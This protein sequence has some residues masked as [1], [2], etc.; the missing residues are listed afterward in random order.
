MPRIVY[1]TEEEM[2]SD[3]YSNLDWAQEQPDQGSLAD[4]VTCWLEE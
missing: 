4:F 1:K 2:K 3:E